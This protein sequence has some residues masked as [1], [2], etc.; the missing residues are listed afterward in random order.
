VLLVLS[1]SFSTYKYSYLLVL[2]F[3]WWDCEVFNLKFVEKSVACMWFS[4]DKK[5]R[6]FSGGDF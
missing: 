5:S 3:F 4:F 1:E 6:M 2:G